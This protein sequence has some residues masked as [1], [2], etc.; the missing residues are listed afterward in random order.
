MA[1]HHVEALMERAT[2][3]QQSKIA[4]VM[5]EWKA[6]KL[7]SSSGALVK[8]YQQA[9]AIAMSEA[10]MSRETPTRSRGYGIGE[11]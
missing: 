11:R 7:R 6:G 2:P 1:K 8:D 10:G 4:K 3:A 5:R 9:V